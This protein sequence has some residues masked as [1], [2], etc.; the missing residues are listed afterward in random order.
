MAT[1]PVHRSQRWTFDGTL[2]RVVDRP[3]RRS[4]DWSVWRPLYGPIWRH[5]D[6]P[7]WR[8]LYRAIRRTVDRALWGSVN[9]TKWGFVYGSVRRTF[10]WSIWWNVRGPVNG[11]LSKQYSALGDL[12]RG[13]IEIGASRRGESHC[14]GAR[15]C[16]PLASLKSP[17]LTQSNSGER[18]RLVSHLK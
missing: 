3:I 9:G 10:D 7:L 4:V 1:E 2:R 12:C 5:V 14:S 11:A 13:I 6:R 18:Y 8:S 16:S 15:E 17:F